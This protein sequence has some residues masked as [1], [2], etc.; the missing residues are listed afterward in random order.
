MNIETKK[1]LAHQVN[2]SRRILA[3]DPEDSG[4]TQQ[5]AAIIIL[6]AGILDRLEKGE[7]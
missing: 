2:E 4:H 5:R 1:L 6:L 3:Q 7:R